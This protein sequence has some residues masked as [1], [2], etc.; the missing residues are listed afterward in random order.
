MD[1]PAVL[2]LLLLGFGGTVT[3][4]T[5]LQ[6]QGRLG[7]GRDPDALTERLYLLTPT[8]LSFVLVGLAF[9]AAGWQPDQDG[10]G[11]MGL[12]LALAGLSGATGIVL[13]LVQPERLRPGWQRRQL[14]G[15]AAR[16]ARPEGS[17][18]FALDVV[19]LRE[20]VRD[21][22]RFATEDEAALAAEAILAD[23]PEVEHVLLVDDRIRAGVRYVER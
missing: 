5:V 4:L 10:W 3:A 1:G 13:W 21:R 23:D 9:V 6:W 15:L 17:G 20:P 18:P 11:L 12:L 22:R 2:G 8:G 19:K 7:R 16:R 14:E